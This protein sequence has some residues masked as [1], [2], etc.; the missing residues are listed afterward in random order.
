MASRLTTCTFCGA[1]C[2]IYLET[3]G[4]QVVGAY[5]S[6]SHPA[7]VG[8]ICVR[9]WHVHEIASSPNRLKTPLIKKNGKLQEA[10]W[11][12][13][14]GYI[15]VRLR[16]IR[17]KYGPDSIALLT[18]PRCS[19]EESYLLQKLA[20]AVLGTNNVDH[21]A[22]VYTNNSIEVLL[23]QLG[24]PA[25]TNSIEGL[26]K[27]ECIIV[28]SVDLA[29]QLPT[30]AGTVL[31]A[32][33]NGTKLIVIGERRQRLAE[34]ADVFL[35]IKPGTEAVLYGAMAKVAV[36]TGMVDLPFIKARCRGYDAF[37]QHIR[38]YDL[39]AAAQT[40][41]VTADAIQAA[42]MAYGKAKAAAILYSSGAESRDA[43]TIQS[44]VNLALATGQL[45]K[46]GAGIF[47]LAEHNNLQGVC[48]MGVLPDRLPGYRPVANAQ[49]RA[50]VEARWKTA[51]PAQPGMPGS[52][53]F[54]PAN[55]GK[56]KALWLCRYDPANTAVTGDVPGT[57]A[58]AELVVTQ[59]LFLTETAK[60]ADVVLPTT[61]FGEERVTFT[62][63]ERRVQIADQVVEPVRGAVPAWRQIVEVARALGADWKYGS[64]A[65][66]MDEIASVVPFYSSVSYKNLARDYG[67]Q[68]PCTKER[69]LGTP[70]L[71]AGAGSFKFAPVARQPQAAADEQFPFTLVFG[72]SHYYWNQNVLIQYS[73]TLK[74]EYRSLLLDFPNGFVEINEEDAK[75][76]KIR[77]NE[78]IQIRSATGVAKINA[79]V[80][81]EIRRGT[82]FMPFFVQKA[83]K[84]VGAG[85]NL[86]LVPVRVEKEATP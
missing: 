20:R 10:T 2:G 22:G 13:A 8:K 33:L 82:V 27:S 51:L 37:L 42:A 38:D 59:H 67:R 15:A 61:A 7:N 63:T 29:K 69:P 80:T 41:G 49:A 81:N 68:W 57:L 86:K 36:D 83:L 64:S 53:V 4:N 48:D 18:S 3:S 43:Q 46:E 78:R 74:R 24:V 79:N 45:G 85:E 47:A 14:I 44:L 40:C 5:P 77:N 60:L 28:D 66:V 54:N 65:D 19:N 34:N 32:K 62:S 71:F 56:L 1:G 58:K 70:Y 73:E 25:S 17:Q 9:G 30:I 11:E 39:L 16:E 12:E 23:D 72:H 35:Q 84:E 76:L 6:M 31:R 50:E 26:A 55:A 52:A 21:G 75:E